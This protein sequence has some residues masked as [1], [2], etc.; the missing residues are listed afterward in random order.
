MAMRSNTR[1]LRMLWI[2]CVAGVDQQGAAN[3]PQ[4]RQRSAP[5][6]LGVSCVPV[7]ASSADD[8]SLK[9]R[10]CPALCLLAQRGLVDILHVE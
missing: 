8:K 1:S 4:E 2:H 9:S 6:N 10:R 5:A 7:V 3:T